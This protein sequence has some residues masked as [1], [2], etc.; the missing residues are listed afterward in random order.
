MRITRGIMSMLTTHKQHTKRL[1]KISI[2]EE[3]A[4]S[5][6][7]G[8]GFMIFQAIIYSQVTLGLRIDC[9]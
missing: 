7:Q 3:H 2:D 4:M 5:A 6:G 8:M 9:R 1:I